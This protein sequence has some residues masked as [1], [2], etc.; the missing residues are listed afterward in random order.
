[1]ANRS[2]V[3]PQP[4]PR[5]RVKNWYERLTLGRAMLTIASI[6]TILV[7]AGGVLA[8]LV[9]PDTFTS[10][11]LAFWWALT[12]ITTVG[13][14]DI[15]PEDLPGRL[16]GSALML[17]GVSLI[18]LVTSIVVA[19]LTLKRSAEQR[20]EEARYREEQ[21]ARLGTIEARLTRMSEP[22]PRESR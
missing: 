14:G 22:P 2:C 10:L 3:T 11:E 17:T 19:I 5:K 20:E 7:F 6:V 21:A 8:R 1:M 12:T 18:P 4:Q 15:V 13:Y 16:V 9:E